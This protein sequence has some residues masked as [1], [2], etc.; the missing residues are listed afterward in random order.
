M[1]TQTENSTNDTSVETIDSTNKFS[2]ENITRFT[3]AEQAY[4]K[5]VHTMDRLQK[6]KDRLLSHFE[7]ALA[8]TDLED[9]VSK[10]KTVEELGEFLSVPENV[11]SFFTD[12]DGHVSPIVSDNDT[13]PTDEEDL[14]FRKGLLI[15]IRQMQ[16]T[17]EEIDKMMDEFNRESGKLHDGMN[18]SMRDFAGE[19][20]D[21]ILSMKEDLQKSD[22]PNKEE[23][24][25]ELSFI[26]SGIT[27]SEVLKVY[28]KHP[29]II[30]HTLMDM[31]KEHFLYGIGKQYRVCIKKARTN[32]SLISFLTETPQT[33]FEAM[34]LPKTMYREGYEGLFI[35]SLIRFFSKQY[36]SSNI[37]KLHI[38]IILMLQRFIK[39]EMDDTM[40]DVYIANIKNYLDRFY[41]EIDR[42]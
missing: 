35:F 22:L 40:R 2:I 38:F 20:M 11:Y 13:N 26:E 31:E 6:N 16:L 9:K 28:D 8:G 1:N 10:F 41:E 27:F 42:K 7:D 3:E 37:K 19:Y 21:H 25:E 17:Q 24:L 23:A 18:S 12:D 15:Y 14:E 36:W 30:G 33:S 5:G 34:Y 29:S 32:S 39:D 4:V